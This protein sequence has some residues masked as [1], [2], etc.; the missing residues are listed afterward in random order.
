V[1]EFTTAASCFH[2]KHPLRVNVTREGDTWVCESPELS[3]LSFGRSLQEALM[4]LYSDFA[5]LWD[6]IARSPDESPT[7]E[8]QLVKSRLLALVESVDPVLV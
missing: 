2:L 6:V 8:A 5:M 3:I 7:R 1:E 4:S